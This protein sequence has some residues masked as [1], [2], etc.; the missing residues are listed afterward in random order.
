M[1]FL[2]FL[3]ALALLP[4]L[5]A[6]ARFAWWLGGE[7]WDANALPLTPLLWLAGGF[8]AAT[9]A[10][11]LLPRPHSLYVFG[12]EATHA[13]AVWM[14]GGKVSGFKVGKDGGH[15]VSDK[16]S[17]WI[18][19]SPYLIPFYPIAALVLWG[20]SSWIFPELS[21]YEF[22]FLAAWGLLWG[23]HLAFT[24]SLM[25]TRQPDFASQ[26]YLFS[27]VVI[28]L[29]N[30]WLVLTLAWLS[31]RPIPAADALA[32][33]TQLIRHDYF[34]VFDGLRTLKDVLM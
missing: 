30:C 10:F 26:G 4:L 29:G 15:V 16:M 28:L 17:A 12:H 34:F 20:L 9:A 21:T 13:A 7:I 3:V 1:K 22:L 24:A 14:S 19:L 5:T 11:L 33:A 23:Y 31:T 6:S 18:S 8:L 32:H 25:K 2:K 27:W